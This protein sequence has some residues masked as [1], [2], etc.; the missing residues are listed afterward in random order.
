[1]RIELITVD[2]EVPPSH[3]PEDL[4]LGIDWLELTPMSRGAILLPTLGQWTRFL[5]F[6]LL[7][8]VF[9]RFLGVQTLPIATVMLAIVVVLSAMMVWY[10]VVTPKALRSAWLFFPSVML[11]LWL[12]ELADKRSSRAM[13]HDGIGS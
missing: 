6:L 2:G 1:M 5:L 13:T 3:L 11:L 8:F 7:R 4:G 9:L 12:A 10:P